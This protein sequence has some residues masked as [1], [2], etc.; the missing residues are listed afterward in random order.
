MDCTEALPERTRLFHIGIPK[1]GTT[2][3]QVAAAA[4]RDELLRQGVQYPGDKVNQRGAVLGFMGRSWGWG[5]GGATTPPRERWDALIA[6]IEADESRRVFF[7]HEFASEANKATARGFV[8]AIGER[9]HVLITLRSFGA[10]LPSAWQQFVKAGTT[11]GFEDWLRAVLADPPDRSV[12][13]RFHRR[14]DQGGVVRRWVKAAGPDR[15]TVIVTDSRRPELLTTGVE[16]L[17]ALRPGTLAAED[18]DGYAA[19]RGLTT[20]EAELFLALNRA[21]EPYDVDWDD[22][23]R[24]VRF[25][26]QRRLMEEPPGAGERLILPDW[27]AVRAAERGAEFAD[28][29]A[30]TGV[31]VIGDLSA[32]AGK[33]PSRSLAEDPVDEVPVELAAEALA[34]MLSAGTW[35]GPDFEDPGEAQLESTLAQ[36]PARR[37][38]RVAI[39]RMVARVWRAVTRGFARGRAAV[40]PGSGTGH[41][42]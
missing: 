7:G 26:A 10:I 12:T 33:P 19:N 11:T 15:V 6:E 17:L 18:L 27:A 21:I 38:L 30:A 8:D 4:K 39:G 28:Q 23:E 22:Y 5:K 14:N 40:L 16:Q 32:L 9:C 1:S 36:V 24:I 35:R 29:I 31:R 2:S 3:L 13:R 20:A 25:G 42:R 34:G 37:L 41:G